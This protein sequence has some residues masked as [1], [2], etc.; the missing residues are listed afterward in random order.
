MPTD[1][2]PRVL[3]AISAAVVAFIDEIR[4]EDRLPSATVFPNREWR[5][6]DTPG[7]TLYFRRPETIAARE[8]LRKRFNRPEW[9]A[10]WS[11]RRI[12]EVQ[13]MV[14]GGAL[15]DASEPNLLRAMEDAAA[16]LDSE[17]P[18]CTVVIPLARLHMGD[19][20]L[21]FPNV[22]IATVD[23]ARYSEIND[24][25]HA[26]IKSTPH[27]DG[28]KAEIGKE[29]DEIIGL[30][31]GRAAAF[32]KVAGDPPLANSRALRM[33]QPIIDLVQLFAVV[34][35]P[36]GPVTISVGD[37]RDPRKHQ[38]PLLMISADGSNI[39]HE[40]LRDFVVSYEMQP[41]H[42][43]EMK[44]W[45][46]GDLID[47]LGKSEEERTNF[48]SLLVNAMHWV[49]EAERQVSPENKVTSYVTAIDMFFA[50]KYV[51]DARRN[52]VRAGQH[53]RTTKGHCGADEALLRDSKRR[54]AFRQA[55][56]RGRSVRTQ[57]ARAKFSCEDEFHGGP[58]HI[59]RPI[60][61][62][63]RR[64]AAILTTV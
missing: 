6:L 25:L 64:A 20:V 11:D 62:V 33:V 54:V 59:Q 41:Q 42:I 22:Q 9:A 35:H 13:A 57:D 43:E 40:N 30:L 27:T 19:L 50:A 17:P 16:M 61:R 24:G 38:A 63:D 39:R 56:R 15:R 12:T 14:I 51:V 36:Y 26:I 58:V 32:V 55:C 23:G 29:A 37:E 46:F 2:D 7:G 18:K 47:A 10:S 3:K 5:F 8:A 53:P 31:R 21:T 52:R 49:A 48:E 34:N 1:R 44:T 4:N 45:G 28:E 60:L